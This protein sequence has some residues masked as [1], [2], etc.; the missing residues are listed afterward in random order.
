MWSLLEPT[1]FFFSF[2]AIG[3]ELR[4]S[5]LLGSQSLY[6]LSH[7]ASLSLCPFVKVVYSTSDSDCSIC[8]D[9]KMRIN[10]KR[11]PSHLMMN[12]KWKWEADFFFILSKCWKCFLLQHNLVY[13]A[14]GKYICL[15][16]CHG[17]GSFCS[18]VR[19]SSEFGKYSLLVS[20]LLWDVY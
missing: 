15:L 7:S 9:L 17:V 12:G 3:F 18:S 14:W 6:H 13:P 19:S 1:S 8:S 11:F 20:S 5:H 16:Q 2:C 4:T 10:L